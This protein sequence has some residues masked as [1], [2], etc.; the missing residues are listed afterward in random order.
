VADADGTN[1]I[2]VRTEKH[3]PNHIR[4]QLMDWR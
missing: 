2:T 1:T 4:L 3:D